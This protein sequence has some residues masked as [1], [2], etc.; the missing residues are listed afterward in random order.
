MP[1]LLILSLFVPKIF[2]ATVFD[3]GGVALVTYD[4]N[5]SFLLAQEPVKL[6]EETL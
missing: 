6:W 1:L 4:R 3:S 5:F 2:T